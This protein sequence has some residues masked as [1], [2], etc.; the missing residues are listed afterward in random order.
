[1]ANIQNCQKEFGL[2]AAVA[3]NRFNFDTQD[4]INTLKNLIDQE[5]LYFQKIIG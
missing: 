2:K 1:M 4:E 3:V 5:D